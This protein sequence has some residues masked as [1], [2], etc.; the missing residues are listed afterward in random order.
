M[1]LT[2]SQGL[3]I[4]MERPFPYLQKQLSYC[5]VKMRRYMGELLPAERGA[6][7]LCTEFHCYSQTGKMPLLPN[8]HLMRAVAHSKMYSENVSITLFLNKVTNKQCSCLGF[9]LMRTALSVGSTQS[10]LLTNTAFYAKHTFCICQVHWSHLH[11]LGWIKCKLLSI[12][13]VN[14]SHI[15]LSTE[16]SARFPLPEELYSF[17]HLKVTL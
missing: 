12:K 16:L 5:T 2:V 6:A 10:I 15:P 13:L 1:Q 14:F 8:L 17:L 9:T 3:C 11:Y 4:S 7:L